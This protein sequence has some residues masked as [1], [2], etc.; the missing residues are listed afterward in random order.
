VSGSSRRI[1]II[2][3]GG[4]LPLEIARAC[5]AAGEF[6]AVY[7]ISEFAA[8]FPPA[9]TQA[10]GTIS[11]LGPGIRF[12]KS[13]KCTELVFVGNFARPR[14]RNIK[15]RP[16]FA[17]IMFLVRNFG[18]LRKSNDGIH[19]AFANEFERRGFNVISPL[20]AAPSLAA[21]A[22]CLTVTR[23]SAETEAAFT[24][25]VAAARNHGLT[26]EGQAIVYGG[27]AVIATEKRA[28]TDAMLRTLSP[29]QA[30]GAFLVKTMSP[31][32]LPT[33][34]PPAI[35]TDTV[36]LAAEQGLAGI[37]VEAKKSI[38]VHPARVKEVA[39]NHGLFVCGIQDH[40]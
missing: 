15:V 39:D 33:M 22:G 9:V 18:V 28:G 26:G 29:E 25:A 36:R 27:G 31:G 3:G 6:V 5:Q 4:D 8:D 24:V 20:V 13:H 23:P 38:I 35:G 16:D 19:R 10:R 30:K 14:D 7:A 32:Q 11:K 40:P 2:A 37:L 12:L 34:D 17:A 1:G 21:E